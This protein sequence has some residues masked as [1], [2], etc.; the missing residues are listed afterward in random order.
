MQ[1]KSSYLRNI[2]IVAE[3][4]MRISLINM[5]WF[6]LNFPIILIA[7]FIFIS[8]TM[9]SI[10]L[11]SGFFSILLVFIFFPSTVAVFAVSRDWVLK[12]QFTFL[13]KN[14]WN[15]FKRNYVQ[16]LYIGFILT[17]VWVVWAVDFYYLNLQHQILGVVISIFG[18]FLLVY[19]INVLAVLIHYDMTKKQQF[20]LAFLLTFGKPQLSILILTILFFGFYLSYRFWFFIL[21]FTVSAS[22]Y[23]IFYLFYRFVI[24]IKEEAELEDSN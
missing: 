3:W 22:S 18:L 10:L 16:S 12:K 13:W 17:I 7:F 23:S 6:M 4:I 15:H 2:N 8:P 21:F 24:N 5:F 1:I 9:E 19:T 20:K 11:L 14:Y